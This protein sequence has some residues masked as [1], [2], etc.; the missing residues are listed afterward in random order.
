MFCQHRRAG[1]TSVRC[2][3]GSRASPDGKPTACEKRRSSPRRSATWR[4]RSGCGRPCATR[5]TRP[6]AA[7]CKAPARDHARRAHARLVRLAGP[8]PAAGGRRARSGIGHHAPLR[9][10]H[11]LRRV[12]RRRA[13]HSDAVADARPQ[14]LKVTLFNGDNFEHC[15]RTWTSAAAAAGKTSSNRRSRSPA[16]A[17]GS[18]S[19]A[20]TGRCR[21]AVRNPY[22]CAAAR[23]TAP[24]PASTDRDHLNYDPS[25]RLRFYQFDPDAPRRGDLLDPLRRL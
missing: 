5:G 11:D 17:A 15:Y 18:P 22:I 8:R 23:R 4:P 25:R 7:N 3:P 20:T 6:T 19:A 21:W 1:C 13:G 9:Q 2:E 12:H 14:K 24:R 10:Q 16:R